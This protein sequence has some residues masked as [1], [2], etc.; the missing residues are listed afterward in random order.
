MQVQRV[1]L[2]PISD[3]LFRS[4]TGQLPE[5]I[6]VKMITP[7][8]IKDLTPRL[9]FIV[10]YPDGVKEQLKQV[11][12]GLFLI[13]AICGGLYYW[14]GLEAVLIALGASYIAQCERN[15]SKP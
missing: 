9:C 14:Y 1:Y 11:L 5:I 12:I 4:G 8:G 15:M 3:N 13:T 7:E 2:R 10:K 6:G